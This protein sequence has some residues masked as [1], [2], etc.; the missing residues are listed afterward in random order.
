MGRL[1]L[2]QDLGVHATIRT[3]D[4]PRHCAGAKRSGPPPGANRERLFSPLCGSSALATTRRTP[5]HCN[6]EEVG[7]RSNLSVHP[8]TSHLR[9]TTPTDSTI[10]SWSA[11]TTRKHM[12][13][14][15]SGCRSRHW[16]RTPSMIRRITW[17]FS[18][19]SRSAIGARV[20]QLNP[21]RNSDG[22][23]SYKRGWNK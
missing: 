4:L 2:E 3:R 10:K 21:S 16:R 15:L 12:M 8:R 13:R 11:G 14:Q 5:H 20:L 17:Q 22:S 9:R 19:L 23:E 1:E 6:E 7:V 18:S